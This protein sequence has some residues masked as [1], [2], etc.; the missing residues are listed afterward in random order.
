MRLKIYV[1]EYWPVYEE[2]ESEGNHFHAEI[3]LSIGEYESYK[4]SFDDFHHWQSII[5]EK[6]RCIGKDV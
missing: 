5:T 6:L 2:Y 3:E 1:D 4:K